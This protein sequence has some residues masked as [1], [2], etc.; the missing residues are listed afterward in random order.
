MLRDTRT[1][2]LHPTNH[3]GDSVVKLVTVD[4]DPSKNRVREDEDNDVS[5][6]TSKGTLRVGA[7][8][9]R[10]LEEVR[11]LLQTARFQLLERSR[12]L[13]TQCSATIQFSA[14][15][16]DEIIDIVLKFFKEAKKC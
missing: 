3:G 11:Q 7:M 8:D 9:E 16:L 13:R 6:G 5:H 2:P 1:L 4:A 10:Q 15:A 14:E 12:T